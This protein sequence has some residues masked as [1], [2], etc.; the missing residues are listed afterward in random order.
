MV[1]LAAVYGASFWRTL[2]VEALQVTASFCKD[3]VQVLTSPMGTPAFQC[4]HYE[5]V[6]R[7]L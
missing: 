5:N 6:N 4:W 7:L 1:F 3:P 2:R